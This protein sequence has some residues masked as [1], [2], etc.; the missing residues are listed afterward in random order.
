MQQSNLNLARKWRSKNFEEIVG[1]DL[2]VRILR[3]SLYTNQ[4]FPVYLFSGQ[5]GCGKTSTARIF[6]TA[7]NC[8]K[9][10]EFQK[11]PKIEFPCNVCTSCI[12]MKNN[13]HP[14][15][16]EMDAA[17]HT[18]VDNVRN[19]IEAATLMPV[20]GKKRV[21]LIDEAHMLSK[22][23]FNAFL[24][25]LEEP[26]TS[27]IFILAT[28]DAEKIIDTVKSRCFQ[29]IFSPIANNFLVEHLSEICT[30]EKIAFEKDGLELIVNQSE[31]SARD[32]INLMEQVRFSVQTITKKDVQHVLGHPDDSQ[33]L[34]LFEIL[35]RD[36]NKNLLNFL[37]EMNFGELSAKFV[38]DQILKLLRVSIY[39]KHEVFLKTNFDA[40]ALK[41]ILDQV[42]INKIIFIMDFFCENEF[43]F[44]K[45]SNK[46]LFLEM[47]FFKITNFSDKNRS[48][49]KLNLTSHSNGF[50][51]AFAKASAGRLAFSPEQSRRVT[52]SARPDPSNSSGVNAALS[53]RSARP[54]LV[55]GFEQLQNQPNDASPWTQ[56]LQKIESLDDP[57][58]LSIFKQANFVKVD[59]DASRVII[60]FYK[61]YSF[62][63]SLLD[64]TRKLWIPFVK[65]IFAVDD[66]ESKIMEAVKKE[67]PNI[68]EKV[69][70]HKAVPV[71]NV[72]VQAN[73]DR[74]ER[75][76]TK[77]DISDKE[78]WKLANML[79]EAF[80][81]ELIEV[82][83]SE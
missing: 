11:S 49:P 7:I 1:Q 36:G 38:W 14:D 20:L 57:L 47:L 4:F 52:T 63:V 60:E 82:K 81:G 41:S 25:I 74:I 29:L 24:K 22:A 6:A 53:S 51:P 44:V 72:Q 2:V 75:Y 56:F 16:I 68:A 46:N 80:P 21:Y 17:S 32:A 71:N 31:G 5:R 9:L 12:A 70:A 19:I 54:E 26:P 64:D 58:V 78:K 18:G 37:T 83:E 76:H 27:V 15:F 66:I 33:I 40:S 61:N 13:K 23:A 35:L 45:T 59:K 79:L 50:D 10:S 55:E 67:D 65:E 48:L 42:S 8:E 39:L 30:K 28:T 73:R 62:L 69:E 34:K 3:N 43:V 77:L